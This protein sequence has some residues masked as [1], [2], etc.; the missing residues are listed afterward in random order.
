MPDRRHTAGACILLSALAIQLA[1]LALTFPL[2]PWEPGQALFHIDHPYHLY[3]VA[4]GRELIAQGL[5]VGYDPFFGAGHLGGMTLN[6]SARLPVLVAAFLSDSV[7]TESIYLVY[8][9]A[10]A[11]IAPAF[12]VVTGLLLR[13]PASQT[14]VAT[15]TGFLFWWLGA[16]RWYHTA[17]MVS[18]V[19]ACFASIPYAAW[20]LRGILLPAGNFPLSG[21]IAAGLLGG[22]GLWLHPLFG[23]VVAMISMTFLAGHFS[24][25]RWTTVLARGASI[26]LI[27][28]A[29][30]LSWILAMRGGS[31][32]FDQPYQ[33]AAGMAF[34]IDALI[35][36][37][38][39]S[40][41]MLL[42]PL[43]ILLALLALAIATAERRREAA[44]FV[45]AGVVC[46]LFAGFGAHA[47]F[48]AKLQ[49]NR[50]LAPGFLLVGL[51]A[52]YAAPGILAW[53]RDQSR[54][55]AFRLAGLFAAILLAAILGRELVREVA[56]GQ[57][58]RY[59]KSPPEVTF[60]PESVAW[61]EKW[62]KD[63][64]TPQGRILFETSLSRK[65]GG[66]HIAG[67]L[68]LRTRR[69]F[70]G[71]P[72]PFLM[73]ERSFWDHS[74]FGRP[75]AEL[76]AERLSAGLELYNVG[77][78]ITHSEELGRR[79]TGLPHARL[80]A[81][82]EGMRIFGLD[83]T[84]S[85]FHSGDAEVMDRGFDRLEVSARPGADLMLRYHW[86]DGIG[87]TPAIQAEPVFLSPDYPPF[88]RILDAPEHFLIHLNR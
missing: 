80:L 39:Q 67:Y 87:F 52:S 40:M 75:L 57:H 31:E 5:W 71:A 70:I 61:L 55:G 42:N 14:I 29:T 77:W 60:P 41:G 4:L 16:F 78:I 6:A 65:H 58:G 25:W 19:C 7:P 27:A 86:I 22:L 45:G 76:S 34:L 26:G 23:V 54:P 11:L 10:C 43:V 47:D 66:G 15:L 18:F 24:R 62:I 72:Y 9:F 73:P 1:L 48:F 21:V 85:Y 12:I 79:V 81:Q 20:V 68:A 17:G 46:I 88:I 8:V 74:A 28:L 44:I 30:N 56:P 13:W 59:G 51:S 50:F 64:T 2:P 33:K 37:W 3:Q 49:P 84:L 36:V 82:R 83:R 53:L 69:E 32:L 35:G 38:N 63:S